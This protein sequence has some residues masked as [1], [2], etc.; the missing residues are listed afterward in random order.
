MRPR[1]DQDYVGVV[2]EDELKQRSNSRGDGKADTPNGLYISDSD[3]IYF[4]V[5][6]LQ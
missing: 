6:C 3:D 4:I 1:R 2:R 5:M